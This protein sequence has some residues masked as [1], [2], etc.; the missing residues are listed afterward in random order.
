M[1]HCSRCGKRAG[2]FSLRA[3][4]EKTQRCDEC[5]IQHNR[6]AQSA[7]ERFQFDFRAFL[8][9]GKLT[10]VHWSALHDRARENGLELSKCLDTVREDMV[11]LLAKTL[12]TGN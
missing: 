8:S 2:G 5:D 3:F 11:L 4:N 1:P 10:A 12:E 6:E 7:L 9:S